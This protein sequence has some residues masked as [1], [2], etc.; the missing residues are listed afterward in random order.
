MNRSPLP[1]RSPARVLRCIGSRAP[2]QPFRV[3]TALLS[4]TRQYV[5]DTVDMRVNPGDSLAG[6]VPALG[7]ELA[8]AIDTMLG[9]RPRNRHRVPTAITMVSCRTGRV[10][11][12]PGDVAWYAL[13][14]EIA[15]PRQLIV[16]DA[17]LVTEHGWR[18]HLGHAGRGPA[19]PRPILFP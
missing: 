13:L 10:V 14:G 9:A 12:L 7:Q 4:P 15:G 17:F 16:A 8:R 11:R 3:V 6:P 5:Q 1:L 19:H 18:T 2:L